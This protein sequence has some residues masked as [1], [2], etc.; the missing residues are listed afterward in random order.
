M[1]L[2]VATLTLIIV[3]KV[4]EASASIGARRR[5][6]E[7]LAPTFGRP[8]EADPVFVNNLFFLT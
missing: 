6:I 3:L 7:A 1:V 2:F 5:F 8:I 4:V